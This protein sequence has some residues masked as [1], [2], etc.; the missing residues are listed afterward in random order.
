MSHTL[1]VG[2]ITRKNDITEMDMLVGDKIAVKYK[3]EKA[4]PVASVVWSQFVN[5]QWIETLHETTDAK[6]INEYIFQKIE[7]IMAR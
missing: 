2:T 5:G 6:N 4:L 7:K 3:K 1:P